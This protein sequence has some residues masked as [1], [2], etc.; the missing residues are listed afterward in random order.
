[1]CSVLHARFCPLTQ[2]IG[3]PLAASLMTLNG[4]LGLRG[5]Q[6]LFIL[7]GLPTMAF[8]VWLLRVLPESPSSAEFLTERERQWAT[9]RMEREQV[10]PVRERGLIRSV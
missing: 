7:E 1:M 9:E 10:G 5:W 6:W 8:G 4:L 2:V 3:A